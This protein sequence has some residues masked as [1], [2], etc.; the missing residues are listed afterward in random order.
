LPR[1]FAGAVNGVEQV[2]VNLLQHYFSTGQNFRTDVAALVDTSPLPVNVRDSD[3]NPPHARGES[4]KC[5]AY[6]AGSIGS[7]RVRQICIFYPDIEFHCILR[8]TR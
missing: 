5:E 8:L 6:P 3:Y 1:S 2:S 7:N 4:T